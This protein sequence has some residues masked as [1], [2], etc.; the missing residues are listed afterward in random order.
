MVTRHSSRRGLGW[1]GYGFGDSIVLQD[2]FHFPVATRNSSPCAKEPP[3]SG[4]H[5]VPPAWTDSCGFQQ[6]LS[7]AKPVHRRPDAPPSSACLL[8]LLRPRHAWRMDDV[9]PRIYGAAESARSWVLTVGPA[10]HSPESAGL[11]SPP[12]GRREAAVYS[13]PRTSEKE[14]LS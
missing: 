8:L 11:L 6:L 2:L 9:D 5:Y 13:E 4:P 12:N 1:E 14:S 3:G 7:L 10:L